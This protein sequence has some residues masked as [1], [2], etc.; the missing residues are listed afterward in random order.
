MARDC[1]DAGSRDDF[2]NSGAPYKR[3][4]RDDGDGFKEKNDDAWGGGGGNQQSNGWGNSNSQ[5]DSK[6]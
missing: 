6:W 5:G 3:P 1:P 2:K 4:R